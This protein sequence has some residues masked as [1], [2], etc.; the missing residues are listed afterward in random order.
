[1]KATCICPHCN[2]ELD[3]ELHFK[4]VVSNARIQTEPYMEKIIDKLLAVKDK[5]M[6]AHISF[7]ESMKER[8]RKQDVLTRAQLKFLNDLHRNHAEDNNRNKQTVQDTGPEQ[9]KD[10]GSHSRDKENL[11]L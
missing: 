11:L 3:F 7:V 9:G 5:M 2:Q 8:V 6:P 10:Q 4:A 1:V